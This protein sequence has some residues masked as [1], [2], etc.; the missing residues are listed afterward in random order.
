M[1]AG[2]IEIKRRIKSITNTK[3]ITKAMG[4]IATTKLRR[5]RVALTRYSKYYNE[6]ENIYDDILAS[7]DS[8]EISKNPYVYGNGCEKK[9]YIVLTSDSGMCGGFNGGVISKLLETMDKKDDN[10]FILVGQHGRTYLSKYKFN[11][12]AEYVEMPDV[13]TNKE[14]SEVVRKVLELYKKNEV[15]EVH[16]VY[17]KFHSTVKLEPVVERILPLSADAK[18]GKRYM[19]DEDDDNYKIESIIYSYLD[20]EIL[21]GMLNSKT[22]EQASRMT[23]MDGATKNADDIINKLTIKFNRIRQTAITQEISEI[24]GGAEAQK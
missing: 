18:K 17:T 2:L 24:V 10:E 14:S 21:N 15:G 8:M 9:L 22:S 20:N 6:F 19:D 1:P 3:K 7:V 16:L 11:T 13:P 23:A 4:L 5:S 12:L